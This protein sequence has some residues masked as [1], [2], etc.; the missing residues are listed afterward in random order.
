MNHEEFAFVNHQLAGMLRDGIPL[1]GSLRQ[2]CSQ[3]QRGK[4]RSELQLLERDLAKGVPLTTA[5]TARKLPELYVQTLQIGARTNDLPTVLTLLADHY[6]TA[7]ATWTRLKGLMVYPVIVLV[8]STGLSFWI[9]LLLPARPGPDG[10]ST[11]VSAGPAKP[12]R[13]RTASSPRNQATTPEPVAHW[14]PS[15]TELYL[16]APPMILFTAAT[17]AFF[18]VSLPSLRRHLNWRLPTFK[19]ANL[20]R[21]ASAMVILLKSGCP[22]PAALAL[23][24]QLERRTCAG[25]ELSR[26]KTRCAEGH[27]KFSDIAAGS[28]IFPPMFVWLVAGAGEDMAAGFQRAAQTY[29][30]RAAYRTELLLYASLP[31][32][33]FFLGLMILS[34]IY[35]VTHLIFNLPQSLSF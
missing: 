7:N 12:A 4:L 2:L 22:L 19:E 34:Q 6:Q 10:L 13:P 11:I 27:P 1:E 5:L 3:M 28:K 30:G 16:W 8:L 9:A 35:P 24:S 32:A 18:A 33:L 25:K 21:F 17:L 14:N 31:V 23:L 26:W 20:S 15:A 29:Q